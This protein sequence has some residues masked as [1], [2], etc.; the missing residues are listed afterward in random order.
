MG[1]APMPFG[2]F[3]AELNEELAAAFII[4]M[5]FSYDQVMDWDSDVVW[6]FVVQ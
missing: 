3:L 4:H 1:I 2:H 6:Q 5:M